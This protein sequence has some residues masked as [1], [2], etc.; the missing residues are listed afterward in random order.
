MELDS[1]GRAPVCLLVA[2]GPPGA[3]KSSLV[4]ALAAAARAAAGVRCSLVCFDDYARPPAD[5]GAT[6]GAFD[7]ARWK[8]RAPR[9]CRP[10]LATRRRSPAAAD[11]RTAAPPRW[12]GSPRC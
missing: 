3:G 10:S 6:D 8:V 11:C 9:V 5:A 2:C 4:A 7:P 1:A 12:T